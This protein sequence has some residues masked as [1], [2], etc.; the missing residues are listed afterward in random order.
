MIPPAYPCVS[1]R[2]VKKGIKICEWV[3]NEKS[4]LNLL[5]NAMPQCLLSVHIMRRDWNMLRLVSL[6]EAYSNHPNSPGFEFFM[7]LFRKH[8]IK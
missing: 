1:S 5:C 4:A 6:G 7:L 3:K 8:S 2:Y